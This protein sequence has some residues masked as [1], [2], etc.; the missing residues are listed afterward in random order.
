MACKDRLEDLSLHAGGDLE[1]EA[2]KAL[3]QHLEQCVECRRELEALKAVVRLAAGF[4]PPA[5][6]PAEFLEGVRAAR[7]R[8]ARKRLL[9]YSVAAA[10]AAI[11]LVVLLAGPFSRDS[12]EGPVEGAGLAKVAPVE[13]ERVGYSEAIVTILPA[14]DESMTVVWIVSEE[15]AA[16][17]N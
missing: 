2:A 8:I 10:A 17:E 14:R 9:R 5:P 7:G 15:V 6:P 12:G 13:V 1:D 4:Q 11:L 3:E 16:Q